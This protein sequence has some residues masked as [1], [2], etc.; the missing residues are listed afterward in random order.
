MNEGLQVKVK[1]Y[2]NESL[3]SLNE[4]FEETSTRFDMGDL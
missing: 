2:L 4:G 1:K 3:K